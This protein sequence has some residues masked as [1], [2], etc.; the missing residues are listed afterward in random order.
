M[1]PRAG[2][3]YD[4]A[5]A[6]VRNFFR[7]SKV[8][9]EVKTW[10]ESR[11]RA[12]ARARDGDGDG[13]RDAEFLE[14][15]EKY[16]RLIERFEENAQQRAE[17]LVEEKAQQ[18]AE[19]K[20][21]QLAEEIQLLRAENE[22]LRQIKQQSTS[23]TSKQAEQRAENSGKRLAEQHAKEMEIVRAK[24]AK[25]IKELEAELELR[26]QNTAGAD[27]VSGAP[28]PGP[29]S[30]SAASSTANSEQESSAGSTDSA[31]TSSSNTRESQTD[32]PPTKPA[33]LKVDPGSGRKTPRSSLGDA[34]AASSSNPEPQSSSSPAQDAADIDMPDA[35]DAA[36][37]VS[38][39]GAQPPSSSSLS[40][41]SDSPP[42]DTTDHPLNAVIDLET[43]EP[44]APL[45]VLTM[46]QFTG[47]CKE[48]LSAAVEWGRENFPEKDVGQFEPGKLM[49]AAV[50]HDICATKSL[51]VIDYD[52]YRPLNKV[53]DKGFAIILCHVVDGKQLSPDK[54]KRNHFVVAVVDWRGVGTF[55]HWGMDGN[56]AEKVRKD[57]E[58]QLG[59]LLLKD[60]KKEFGR[61]TGNTCLLQCLAGVAPCLEIEPPKGDQQEKRFFWLIIAFQ[62]WI[63]RHNEKATSADTRTAIVEG[64]LA[65]G[66]PPGSAGQHGDKAMVEG[67]PSDGSVPQSP[68][69]AAPFTSAQFAPPAGPSRRPLP[70]GRTTAAG[71]TST[72]SGRS[73]LP[74]GSPPELS[75]RSMHVDDMGPDLAENLWKKWGPSVGGIFRIEGLSPPTPAELKKMIKQ[76]N[77]K[78]DLFGVKYSLDK[79][80]MCRLYVADPEGGF[81]VPD[82][83]D[84]VPQED[85]EQFLDDVCANPPKKA[86]N[87]YVGP[88]C[89][90]PKERFNGL[91]H[92]G[93]LAD[94]EEL[95]RQKAK[96][97]GD[98]RKDWYVPGVTTPYEHIGHRLS[99]TCFHREDAHYWSANIS[100]S[101]VKIWL[102]IKPESTGAFEAYVRER[103]S[104]LDCD[105]WLRHHNLLIG[106]STL[107]E[108]GV[109]FEVLSAQPGT[110]VVTSPGQ[111]HMVVNRTPSFATAINFLMP[112]DSLFPEPAIKVCEDC[113]LA[114]AKEEKLWD[115][116]HVGEGETQLSSRP[117]R[118]A[119]LRP[120]ALRP[121]V[122]SASR[123][124][125]S[126]KNRPAAKRMN[127]DSPGKR[128]QEK[129]EL[130]LKTLAK[131]LTNKKAMLRRTSR[132]SNNEKMADTPQTSTHQ[133]TSTFAESGAT[134]LKRLN[135]GGDNS[136]SKRQKLTS[137]DDMARDLSGSQ[138]KKRLRSHVL[139]F[140]KD[141][142]PVPAAWDT[143]ADIEQQVKTYV[144]FA[145]QSENR[146]H[147]YKMRALVYFAYAFKKADCR[148]NSASTALSAGALADM[149]RV[150]SDSWISRRRKFSHFGVHWIPLLP[151]DDAE[152]RATFRDYE[153]CSNAD[154]KKLQD[155]I[156]DESLQPFSQAF[157]DAILGCTRFVWQA[158]SV[159]ELE[160]MSTDSLLSLLTIR[161]LEE[162]ET[163]KTCET[164][165]DAVLA[166]PLCELCSKGGCDCISRCF[167]KPPPRLVGHGPGVLSLEAAGDSQG[168]AYKQNALLGQITGRLFPPGATSDDGNDIAMVKPDGET[169]GKLHIAGQGNIF[170]FASHKGGNARVK[171]MAISGK[172][173]LVL[174]ATR[175]IS[176][177]AEIS[178]DF[179]GCCR[180]KV[181][182]SEGAASFT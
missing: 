68:Q 59:C 178:G 96:E 8:P 112:S 5:P 57:C 174:I 44:Q 136:A 79:Q 88:Q 31:S 158:M 89:T 58:E 150:Y 10:V 176:G 182:I 56:L 39:P 160:H 55:T 61:Y 120:A 172:Y 21:Q 20:A 17:K 152:S 154:L 38:N 113:G 81:S 124:S 73:P 157:V 37:P 140:V 22:E 126:G 175:D 33:P 29:L 3:F 94:L 83:S 161:H 42:H 4:G 139:A 2:G 50:F 90:D 142:P 26:R 146:G 51:P 45:Q 98:S 106:P 166:G 34:H 60:S 104:S 151:F 30:S 91:L 16:T 95:R 129:P 35:A 181:C 168:I 52:D 80:G 108:A 97:R 179:R 87:Y 147:F 123:T 165:P 159:E 127:I 125:P 86:I 15:K 63:D 53:K 101:G 23:R 28:A 163:D 148:N 13:A 85:S 114:Y 46:P 173:R 40:S 100:L 92:P 128:L 70:G 115:F 164:R 111:Y 64:H 156:Q 1:A 134:E 6:V 103:Y 118:T 133:T 167:V 65:A 75:L 36:P 145:Y 143:K 77:K 99:A 155:G 11:D 107:R 32:A 93:K 110:M 131:T 71:G 149:K 69:S 47:T 48:K 66:P 119:A 130:P 27:A 82:F 12:R 121:A 177:E 41:P 9:D 162:N 116:E 18:L 105:Q 171:A 76:P 132:L 170:Q 62:C 180:C 84:A 141:W 24:A 72:A 19:K 117:K 74:L 78:W 43:S 138:A 137:L 135:T 169:T 102:V 14:L 54:H 67:V 153:R 7:S 25:R 49:S 122:S 144:D 109:E